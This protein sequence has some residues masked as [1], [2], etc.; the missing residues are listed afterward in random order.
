[1]D[2]SALDFFK[3]EIHKD[4]TAEVRLTAVKNLYL[5]ASAMKEKNV[6]EELIP[7][8]NK[9][10]GLAGPGGPSTGNDNPLA[11][12]DEFLFTMATQYAVLRHYI[13]EEHYTNLIEPLVH[14]AQQEETVIRDEAIKS[15]CIICEEKPNLVRQQVLGHLNAMATKTEFTTRVSACALFGTVYKIHSKAAAS[16]A[17]ADE[18]ANVRKEL[19]QTYLTICNDD[20][21]MVRRA[22]ANKIHDF[23]KELELE[24]MMGSVFLDAYKNLANEETQDS[25]RVNIVH[26]TIEMAKKIRA[27]APPD[28]QDGLNNEHT[29][30]VIQA[31]CV[32]RSWRVKLTVAKNLDKLIQHFGPDITSSTLKDEFFR[33]LKDPEQEVRKEA[34]KIIEPC[35]KITWDKIE[36]AKLMDGGILQEIVK[37]MS[38]EGHLLTDSAQPVRA[39]LAHVMGPVVEKAGKDLTARKLLPTIVELMKDEFHDVRLNI[40][41]HAGTICDVLGTDTFM[42]SCLHTIQTLIMDNHWRIRRNVV[43]QVP[44]LGKMFGVEMYQQKLEALFISSLKDS[45]FSVRKEALEQLKQMADHFG[46]QWTAEHLLPKILDLY[47]GAGNNQT[48]YANRVTTLQALPKLW[49]SLSSESAVGTGIVLVLKALKDSVPNV[50]F[51]ACKVLI[52]LLSMKQ[53]DN[54]A[55]KAAHADLI[56]KVKP[57]L[58]QGELQNDSDSDVQYYAQQALKLCE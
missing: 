18:Y 10:I 33:L 13:K 30:P 5:I 28:E 35:L 55:A 57:A 48:G 21:P 47:G 16:P 58:L 22:S 20:T 32:D 2:F 49:E 7:F 39:A 9:E 42:T 46:P 4:N 17:T 56:S 24:D 8:L 15:I 12:D 36:F 34:V 45:V 44:K 38:N 3:E 50:R 41:S 43:E 23:V 29:Y 14:L 27:G 51:C 25:I 54:A 19:C 37:C 31:A 53:A 1:M 52:D 26:T 6:A 11:N 40:V